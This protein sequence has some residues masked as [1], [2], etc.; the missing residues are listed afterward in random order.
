M[1]L[2][3]KPTLVALAKVNAL[4]MTGVGWGWG[5]FW[6]MLWQDH[7]YSDLVGSVLSFPAADRELKNVDHET[8]IKGQHQL[9]K[10]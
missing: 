7:S 1:V 4:I 3:K 2:A 8:L 10:E 9:H 6:L 5:I